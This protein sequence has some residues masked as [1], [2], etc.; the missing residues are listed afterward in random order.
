MEKV[1]SVDLGG[2]QGAATLAFEK[3]G[4]YVTEI[5]KMNSGASQLVPTRLTLTQKQMELLGSVVPEKRNLDKLGEI[6]I[7][8]EATLDPEDGVCFVY[9]KRCP[10]EFD[11]LYEDSDVAKACGITCGKLMAAYSYQL[12]KNLIT[13]N[14]DYLSNDDLSNIELLVGCPTTSKW[15]DK[16]P[17]KAYA[18]LIRAATGIENVRIVPESRAALFSCVEQAGKHFSAEDGVMV[19]DFGSTTMDYTYMLMGKKMLEFS[20]DLGASLIEESMLRKAYEQAQAKAVSMGK[21]LLPMHKQKRMT[22]LLTSMRKGKEEFFQGAATEIDIVCRFDT[23]D[24][25]TPSVTYLIN[26]NSVEEVLTKV[27]HEVSFN[28]VNTVIGSWKSLYRNSLKKAL[29]ILNKEKLPCGE[30]FLTGGASRMGFI[31]TA[32][33]EEFKNIKGLK[34]TSEPNPGFSVSKGLCWVAVVEAKLDECIEMA[35]EEIRKND[36]VSVAGLNKNISSNLWPI[37]TEIIMGC[38][39][40]WADSAEDYSANDLS[41]MI[42][43]ACNRPENK[44]KI[45]KITN[46]EVNAWKKQY[47]DAILDAVN[48]QTKK[49]YSDEVSKH[50]VITRDIWENLSKENIII[51]FDPAEI[52]SKLDLNTIAWK[53]ISVSISLVIALALGIL[54][55]SIPIVGPI[56]TGLSIPVTQLF[57]SDEKMDKSRTQKQRRRISSQLPRVLKKDDI[58]KVFDNAVS[59]TIGSVML[60]YDQVLDKSLRVAFDI[61][62]L[63]RFDIGGE[64]EPA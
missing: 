24:G 9:Y 50:M 62:T 59:D 35:A 51:D 34:V 8:E 21:K 25:E 1:I 64:N 22:R 41:R 57:L 58:T 13:Y 36:S 19:I 30:I 2:C 31:K 18:K 28:S 12:I 3:E 43:E 10:E 55:G 27:E 4:K 42:E 45:Q 5:L 40:T 63:R 15:T 17:R 37:I 60:D 23:S 47:D 56:I 54:L 7:G 48:R 33:E 39:E 29:E 53:V 61:V 49:L 52:I 32:C 16:A 20:L 6:R 44:S 14:P 46:C 38:A 26:K 11:D